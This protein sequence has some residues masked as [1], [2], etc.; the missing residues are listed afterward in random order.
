MLSLRTNLIAAVLIGLAASAAAAAQDDMERLRQFTQGNPPFLRFAI[1]DGRLTLGSRIA[2]NFQIPARTVNGVKESINLTSDRGRPI[3]NYELSTPKELLKMSVAAASGK[4]H[5]SRSPRGKSSFSSMEFQQAPDEK[6]TL[7][8]G[9]GKSRQV[10]RAASLWHLAL[11]QPKECQ[12][13]L[14]PLLEKLRPDWKVATLAGQVETSLLAHAVPDTAANNAKWA[15]LVEQLGNDEFA[16]REAADRSLR[17]GGVSA[18]NYLRRLNTSR[19]DAEQQFR[20]RRILAAFTV[21]SDDDSADEAATTLA[22]NPAVW[23]V[24][25]GRPEVATRKIAARQLASLLG[26]AIDVDPTAAPETQKAKREQLR[27]RIEG[28]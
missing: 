2:G 9:E 19:L 5:I 26:R 17:A 1:I 10:Y 12:E 18:L 3:L 8:L 24:L 28:K 25:L 23:L 13:Y 27:T 21:Q 14:F 15:S 7:T 11:A 16:K 6:T 4:V 22:R 20:I